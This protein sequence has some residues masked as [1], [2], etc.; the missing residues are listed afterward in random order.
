MDEQL[1]NI[2]FKP[3]SGKLRQV[4]P[5][6][7]ANKKF[8]DIPN[9]E[10]LFVW[11]YA[12]A[13]SP[14]NPEL[15]D[16]IRAR[17][18][19]AQALKDTDKKH[20]FSNLEFPEKVKEAIEEMKKYNPDVRAVA[21]RIIQTTFNNLEKLTNVDDDSFIYTDSDGQK[22][23]DWTGRKQYVDSVAKISETIPGLIAQM[24]H[25]FGISDSKSDSA[26][27]KSIDKFHENNLD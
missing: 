12:C 10:F 7:K 14:V 5:E 26:L 13:S 18:A 22:K 2:L 19:A 17:S 24:E 3:Q 1:P 15:P 27:K 21:K 23:T 8:D 25:G 9:D 11:Y 20:K 6:L 4:Y 16:T